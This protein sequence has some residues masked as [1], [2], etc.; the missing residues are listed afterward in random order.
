MAGHCMQLHVP[1][2]V[3]LLRTTSG[4]HRKPL[5]LGTTVCTSVIRREQRRY[6]KGGANC[7][8]GSKTIDR[9]AH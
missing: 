3:V 2:Y 7:Y 6:R 8:V 4:L 9:R 1:F 5:D